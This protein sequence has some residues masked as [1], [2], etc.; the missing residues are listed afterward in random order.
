MAQRKD[1]YPGEEFLT[2]AGLV[3]SRGERSLREERPPRTAAELADDLNKGELWGGRRMTAV[4]VALPAI[5]VGGV[6]LH[7]MGAVIGTPLRPAA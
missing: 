3:H 4:R 7:G 2:N 5:S 6:P 1:L